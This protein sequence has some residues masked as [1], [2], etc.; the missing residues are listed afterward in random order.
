MLKFSKCFLFWWLLGS[1]F[2]Y[3]HAQ[4]NNP[5]SHSISVGAYYSTGDYGES[6]DTS[7]IYLPITYEHT[8]SNWKF[9]LTVPH[10]QV[11]G[12]GNVLINVGGVSRAELSEE[13]VRSRGIGDIIA[14]TTYQFAQFWENSPLLDLTFEVK[15]P[16][17][18]KNK[19]LGTGEYDYAMQ[20]DFS[21]YVG[22]VT[23]FGTLGYRERGK[24]ELY[25]DL[26]DSAYFSM[27]AAAA[28]SD[29]WSYGFIYDYR[30]AASDLSDETHEI[31]PFLSWDPSAKWN[32]TTL[33][34]LGLTESSPDFSIYTVLSYRW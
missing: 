10:L 5:V 18:D 30:E 28:L 29:T 19:A 15:M 2:S 13:S 7:L 8:R 3:S 9:K 21:H 11:D 27:G 25:V 4:Q 16:T 31:L 33:A 17:A 34:S 26:R 12:L 24:S 23:V 14:T 32:L 6:T 20:L 1:L 22:S